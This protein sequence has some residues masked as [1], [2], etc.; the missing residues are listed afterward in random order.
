MSRIPENHDHTQILLGEYAAAQEDYLH[1][2]NFPWQIGG[3]L[4]AGTFVFWGLLLDRQPN[5]AAYGVGSLM[6]S[7]LMSTWIMYAHH[8]CETLARGTGNHSLVSAGGDRP[9]R[10]GDRP[11]EVGR[12]S[13]HQPASFFAFGAAGN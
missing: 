12:P 6:V 10:I 7:L 8:C 3:I 2:D 1:N 11:R 4:I 9:L 5:P 13:R